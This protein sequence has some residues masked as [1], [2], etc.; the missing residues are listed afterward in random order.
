ML[1]ALDGITAAA[2]AGLKEHDRLMLARQTIMRK[3][4]GRPQSSK[5]PE[6]I[7]LV[8]ARPMVSTGMIAKALSVTPRAALRIAGELNLRELTGRGR[9]RTWGVI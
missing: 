2:E 9:F 3:L 6:L 7:D 5:L 4:V 8:L 1:A